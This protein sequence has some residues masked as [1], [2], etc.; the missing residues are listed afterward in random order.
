LGYAWIIDVLGSG[1]LVFLFALGRL[2]WIV[3]GMDVGR[4]EAGI[5]ADE[6]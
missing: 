6:K 3:P 4:L 2:G 5:C 1:T